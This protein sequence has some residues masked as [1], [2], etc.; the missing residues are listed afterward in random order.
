[1]GVFQNNAITDQGRLLLSH[2][3]MGAIFT[4][5]KIVMGSGTLPSG[6][7]P[8]NIRNVVEPVIE[9]AINKKKRGNDGTVTIGGKY[10][11]QDISTGFYFRELA[12]YAKAVDTSGGEVAAECLYSYGNAGSTA[13]YMPAYTSGQ[14][15]ERQIDVVTYIGNDT[16]VDLYIDSSL[17]GGGGLVVV[18]AGETVPVEDRLEG[19]L[20]FI[21][22]ETLSLSLTPE[23]TVIF[24]E[25]D[26]GGGT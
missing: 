18:P 4:P 5:T 9:L 6:T 26:E 14:P 20:Y 15:V 22:R 7:T 12:I 23:I 21:E 17:Q 24:D 13:D 11:N 25:Y 10:K 8:R 3:Q 2:V 16:Q 1:M 19:F